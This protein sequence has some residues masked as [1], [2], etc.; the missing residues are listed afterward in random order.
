MLVGHWVQH[1]EHLSRRKL[2]CALRAGKAKVLALALKD[3]GIRA[4]EKV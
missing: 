3:A 1:A 4:G 2:A